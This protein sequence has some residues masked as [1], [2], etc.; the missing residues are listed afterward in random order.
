MV[1]GGLN[2]RRKQHE[3]KR[4][5]LGFLLALPACFASECAPIG[6]W[7]EQDAKR[8]HAMTPKLRINCRLSGNEASQDVQLHSSNP[9][10]GGCVCNA[11]AVACDSADCNRSCN[12]LM[13]VPFLSLFAVA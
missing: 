8:A 5:L 7:C 6:N 11:V 13:G 9:K 1:V 12:K 10:D 3:G 2:S 4:S